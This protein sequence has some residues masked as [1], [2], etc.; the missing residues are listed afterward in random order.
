MD[1]FKKFVKRIDDDFGYDN[2]KLARDLLKIAE[3]YQSLQL[4]QTGVKRSFFGVKYL[5]ID[6]KTRV[7]YGFN[8]KYLGTTYTFQRKSFFWNDVAWSYASSHIGKSLKEI[9]D[10]LKWHEKNKKYKIKCVF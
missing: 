9:L 5:Y 4:Q 7:R 8:I 1:L 2:E 3:E 6:E 10:Y